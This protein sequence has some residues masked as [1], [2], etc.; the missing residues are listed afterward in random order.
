MGPCIMKRA[1]VTLNGPNGKWPN[2]EDAVRRLGV[3]VGRDALHDAEVDAR[4][5]LAVDKVLS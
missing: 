2:L 3:E 1:A 5:A 4:A